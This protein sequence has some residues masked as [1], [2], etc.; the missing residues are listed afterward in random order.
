[1]AP[2]GADAL[3]ELVRDWVGAGPSV[4]ALPALVGARSGGNPFLAVEIVLS[5]L[6]TGRLVGRRGA[7]ELVTEIDAVDVPATVQAL[8][9]A[10][11]DR[12]GEREKQLLYTAAVIGKEFQR[13]LLEAVLGAS[14]GDVD[15]AIAALLAAEMI[16]ERAIYPVA[17]YAFKHPLTHEV[18]LGAQLT[19]ARRARHAAVAGAIE[20]AEAERLDEHAGL[21]AHHWT[22]AGDALR[23]GGW[24]VRAA[25]WVRATDLAASGRHW[26]HARRLLAPLPD[27]PERTRLFLDVYPELIS[28]LDRL[29][30]EAAESEAVYAE[31]IDLTR[32]AGDRRTE[33]LVEAA[34][35]HLRSGLVDFPGVIEHAMRAVTL[36]DAEGDRPVQLL[37]RHALGRALMWKARL[38][39]ALA[40]FDEAAEIG[41]GD[42]AVQVE[43]LGWRPYV[44]CL[45]LRAMVYNWMGRFREGLPFLEKLSELLRGL[46]A[47][48]DIA[49][50]AGDRI[51]T[52]WV[53]GDAE[54]ARHVSS[55]ALRMAERFGADHNIVYALLTCGTASC[56]AL[57]W[58]EADGFFQRARQRIATTGAGAEWGS[59]I[60]GQWAVALAA[61][62]DRERSLALARSAIEQSRAHA[63]PLVTAINGAHRARALRMIDGR[64]HLHEIE[65]QIA[66]TLDL[67]RRADMRSWVP[68]VLLERAGLARLRHDSDGM[69]RDLAEARRLFA[70]MGVTG[71][72]EY[73]RSI[74]A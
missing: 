67:Y 54:R 2:L 1:M 59:V 21:L 4:A 61:M 53:L 40:V 66:E 36:A 18:A 35:A 62:G 46:A 9:A 3:A 49:S 42:E 32:R 52:C 38:H 39:D 16:Y 50:V 12:L 63:L 29:G 37:A 74:E 23:A 30:V 45:S 43:V 64:E 69:A 5:L 8:L 14:V 20:A 10:R 31:A 28:T 55:E 17:E 51:W 41:G 71:W 72:D 65:L 15:A 22:E 56:L 34:Y 11:I 68:L 73:A 7:Y 44:E 13:P 24:H 58:E 33:G 48:S 47:H 57:R 60:D 26:T 6:D 70:Q 25:R 19:A 27:S